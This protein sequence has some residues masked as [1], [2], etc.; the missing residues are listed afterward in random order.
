VRRDSSLEAPNAWLPLEPLCSEW[1][2]TNE[3]S[4]VFLG[5]F[6]LRFLLKN[7][8]FPF[9][10]RKK[11]IWPTPLRAKSACWGAWVQ[12]PCPPR[13]MA[14]C[15]RHISVIYCVLSLVSS[16]FGCFLPYKMYWDLGTEFLSLQCLSRPI[17]SSFMVFSIS[18]SYC[19]IGTQWPFLILAVKPLLAHY[20]SS[21]N[22]KKKILSSDLA[23]GTSSIK[24]CGTP[25][26]DTEPP[27]TTPTSVTFAKTDPPSPLIFLLFFL[28]FSL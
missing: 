2:N 24:T 11:L 10:M 5:K 14:A 4:F 27:W 22:G 20:T 15:P 13:C 16:F 3:R 18:S 1:K 21:F 8:L 9:K 19:N 7:W 28:S 26:P 23:L 12:K 25:A 17:E 6:P